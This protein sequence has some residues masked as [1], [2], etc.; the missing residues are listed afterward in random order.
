MKGGPADN[1]Y[2]IP[3][4]FRSVTSSNT[5]AEVNKDGMETLVPLLMKLQ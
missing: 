5:T 2:D 1:M 4:S 3:P